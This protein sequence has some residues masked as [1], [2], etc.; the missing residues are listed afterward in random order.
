MRM[1]SPGT[2]ARRRPGILLLTGRCAALPRRCPQ[3]DNESSY[4]R[5]SGSSLGGGTFWGLCQLL[6]GVADF[7]EMLELSAKGN[8]AH[9]RAPA[10]FLGWMGRRC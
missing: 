9:V 10:A 5:V 1:R 8:N 2:P 6:T 7:D 3:V 4:E